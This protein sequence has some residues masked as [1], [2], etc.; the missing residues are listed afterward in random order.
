[1]EQDECWSRDALSCVDTSISAPWAA[2]MPE[3]VLDEGGDAPEQTCL[4]IYACTEQSW[5][6]VEKTV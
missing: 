4:L 3:P 1:M 2:H 5:R 6:K